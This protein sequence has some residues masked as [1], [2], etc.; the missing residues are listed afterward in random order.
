MTRASNLTADRN[1]LFLPSK[2]ANNNCASEKKELGATDLS[3][4]STEKDCNLFHL[5]PFIFWTRVTDKL[6][7]SNLQ[8]NPVFV[9]TVTWVRRK[10]PLIDRSMPLFTFKDK[11]EQ[12]GFG[13]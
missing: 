5:L 3:V 10:I 6:L 13:L 8:A 11:H 9:F 7:Y 2:T 4:Y 12:N 1:N